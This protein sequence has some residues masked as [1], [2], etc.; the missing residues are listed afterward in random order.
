MKKFQFN[1]KLT[2]FL[3]SLFV[4]LLLVILGSQNKYCLSFGFV[5]LGASLMLFVWYNN[6]K[7]QKSLEDLEKDIDHVEN[8][9]SG[10]TLDEEETEEELFLENEE[11]KVYVLKQLYIRQKKLRKKKKQS[12][13]LFNICGVALIVLGFVALF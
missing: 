5:M 7:M 8:L 13:I 12:M 9:D 3:V 10:E 6:E 1:F 11:E 4:S 2:A